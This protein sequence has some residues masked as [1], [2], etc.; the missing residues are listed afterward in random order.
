MARL[1]PLDPRPSRADPEA[2]TTR[3]E[4]EK[5]STGF[6]WTTAAILG[7]IGVT[8]LI[9]VENGVEKC[10]QRHQRRGDW[11]RCRNGR[12]K[13][14]GAGGRGRDRGRDRTRARTE[15]PTEARGSSLRRERSYSRR[16]SKSVVFEESS[17]PGPNQKLRR[18]G[19]EGSPTRGRGRSHTPGGD[20]SSQSRSSRRSESLLR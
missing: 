13:G 2:R 20:R 18:E 9:N 11:D 8:M 19:Q 16:R 17:E 12:D 10:E 3:K 1:L 5:T 6:G 4:I 7:V 15:T 14:D